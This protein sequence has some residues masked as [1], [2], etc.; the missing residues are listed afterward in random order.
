MTTETVRC[1]DCGA[2]V[3]GIPELRADHLYV[4]AI[5]G[6]WAAYTQLMGRQLSDPRLTGVHMLAVDVYMAQHPGTPGR[7]AA[8]SVWVHLVGLCL[9]L[10]HDF[11]VV[12]SAR[13]KARVAAP[14]A[15]FEW[16]AP[17]ASLGAVTVL[18]VLAAP[19]AEGATA[20]RRWAESVWSAWTAHHAA[21]RARAAELLTS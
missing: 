15:T 19:D 10:E 14:D 9:V 6:C 16:L 4:G 7:Q 13:A 17:P 3:P 1:H 20:V 5:A 21:I 8:Q 18:D 2:M 11:N 12:M